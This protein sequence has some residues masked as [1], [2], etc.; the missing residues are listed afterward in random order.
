MGNFISKLSKIVL[1][2]TICTAMSACCSFPIFPG[3]EGHCARLEWEQLVI[4][5]QYEQALAELD[6]DRIVFSNFGPSLL[7][8]DILNVL[9]NKRAVQ[10][11]DLLYYERYQDYSE[12]WAWPIRF[13]VALLEYLDEG[14][15]S[16]ETLAGLEQY[17]KEMK[18]S[19]LEYTFW[20]D[21]M[22]DIR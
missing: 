20:L 7:G 12:S 9:V 10:K 14:K 5:G 16:E 4:D 1:L 8:Y 11:E 15:I 2:V 19:V 13:F 22:K 3:M 17:R 6:R 21:A 18:G